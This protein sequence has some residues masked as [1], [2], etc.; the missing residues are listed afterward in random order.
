MNSPI[1]QGFHDAI[2]KGTLSGHQVSGVRFVLQDGA[3]HAVD[4]S[5]LA[6]RLAS[7][8]AFREAY[9]KARPVILEPIMLVEVVAPV[10][11]QGTRL[12]NFSIFHVF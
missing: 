3:Y 4:S 10:E 7:L 5:E 6:F 12:L 9:A 8:G 1:L 2:E 11:F